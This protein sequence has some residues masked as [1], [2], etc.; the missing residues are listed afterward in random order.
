MVYDERGNFI[1]DTHWREDYDLA[2]GDDLELERGGVI[3][4]VGECVGSSDQDLSELIDK[5]VE[6]KVRR[7]AVAA[8]RRPPATPVAPLHVLKPQSTTQKHLH[9][10]IG[11]PSGHHGRAVIPKESP[12][13][14]R[15]HRQA[16]VQSG[17]VRPPK[18]QRREVSPP[19]KNGYA[20]SLFGATLTLSGWS[21]SQPPSRHLL[22]T[23]HTQE[24][25][26]P[27]SSPN[28]GNH[29]NHPGPVPDV[30]R[31]QSSLQKAPSHSSRGPVLQVTDAHTS[32]QSIPR[33]RSSLR[34]ESSLFADLGKSDSLEEG[35]TAFDKTISLTTNQ[36]TK[37]RERSSI[38][39]SRSINQDLS[40]LREDNRN[41]EQESPNENGKPLKRGASNDAQKK[42]GLIT[43]EGRAPSHKPHNPK[44]V[45]LTHDEVATPRNQ[46]ILDEPRTELRIKSRKKRGLLMVS[47]RHTMH[48]STPAPETAGVGPDARSPSR[49]NTQPDGGC[50][51][52]ES[53]DVRR[54]NRE[55]TR[56]T[57]AEEIQQNASR[58][59]KTKTGSDDNN[60][61]GHNARS[62]VGGSNSDEMQ[63]P[64]KHKL[65]SEKAAEGGGM[66][67]GGDTNTAETCVTGNRRRLTSKPPSSTECAISLSGVDR[68][69]GHLTLDKKGDKGAESEPPPPRLA[70]L[71]RRNIKSREVIGL[72]FEDESGPA[73]AVQRNGRIQEE[74]PADSQSGQATRN[75][76]QE[77]NVS[78]NH[79]A[80]IT[81]RADPE[82]GF[83]I[84]G[85]SVVKEPTMLQGQNSRE[86]NLS[87]HRLADASIPADEAASTTAAKQSMPPVANPATRGKKAAKPSDAAGQMPVCP[88]STESAG[89]PSLHQNPRKMGAQVQAD[90]GSTRSSLPGFSRANGGPWSREAHDLFDF[91]RPS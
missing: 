43:N 83:Q 19:S 63:Y 17:D 87:G 82:P 9:D 20:Q 54:P 56:P 15:Q 59:K 33:P 49:S 29:N 23:R 68:D 30:A 78:R 6:E 64:D 3:I 27:S 41:L 69:R 10:V 7:Q 16:P 40:R 38:L 81:A 37:K 12:Y 4:Q 89:G 46:P 47:E 71:G 70:K 74:L 21:A 34:P 2:D 79:L 77:R 61:Y 32:R 25:I 67:E 52:K 58:Q 57:S 66:N 42:N 55:H 75:Q 62:P 44:I 39:S 22:K 76:H 90:K 14:E 31:E 1:G 5:R 86:P 80:T 85:L 50:S 45:D 73:A 28:T 60:V 13:E 91:K 84:T 24:E 65:T 36:K 35:S 18:R 26:A 51:V 53:E 11:T 88:L 72:I 8:A 48:N